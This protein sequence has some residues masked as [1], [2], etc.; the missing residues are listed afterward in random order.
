[1]WAN[2]RRPW[3]VQ[4]GRDGKTRFRLGQPFT[5]FCKVGPTPKAFCGESKGQREH[6]H[7]DLPKTKGCLRL[8]PL[9]LLRGKVSLEVKQLVLSLGPST[10]SLRTRSA[11]SC[12]AVLCC[13]VLRHYF[14]TR[15]GPLQLTQELSQ[16]AMLCF[17]L[18][19]IQPRFC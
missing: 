13:F 16:A 5:P 8:K 1:M 10:M 11:L 18:S 7:Q 19:L 6:I 2:A 4:T 15:L 14:L 17:V 9:K 3:N 12:S